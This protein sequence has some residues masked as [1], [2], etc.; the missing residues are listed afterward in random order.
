MKTNKDYLIITFK[1]ITY[2]MDAEYKCKGKKQGRI[3]PV[4]KQVSSGCGMCFASFDLDEQEWIK[5]LK[6]NDIKY[7]T[8]VKVNF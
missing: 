3:I 5:F 1:T 2:A 8:I 6:T 7:E 4:P